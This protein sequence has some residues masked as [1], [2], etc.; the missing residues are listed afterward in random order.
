MALK[1]SVEYTGVKVIVKTQSGVLDISSD[2]QEA[3]VSHKTGAVSSLSVRL[4]NYAGHLEGKYTGLIHCG[5]LAYCAFLV[6][7]VEYPQF[8]GRI[9]QVPVSMLN[10]ASWSF[11]AMDVIWDLQ[12]KYWN[13]YTVASQNEFF[14]DDAAIV[15]GAEKQGINDSGI[16]NTLYTFLLE[17]AGLPAEGVHIGAFPDTSG[18]MKQVVK[19]TVCNVSADPDVFEQLFE[20]LF[21]AAGTGLTASSTGQKTASASMTPTDEFVS[22]VAKLCGGLPFDTPYEN[23]CQQC[24]LSVKR[25]HAFEQPVEPW[26]AL[27]T[28]DTPCGSYGLSNGAN[29]SAAKQ[30][31]MLSERAKDLLAESNN[32]PCLAVLNY[33]LPD[34]HN[35][36]QGKTKD[37]IDASECDW[38]LVYN[39]TVINKRQQLTALLPSETTNTS[40][41]TST[42]SATKTG[43]E[44]AQNT[45]DGLPAKLAGWLQKYPLGK[46]EYCE[47]EAPGCEQ[48]WSY[49][50]GYCNYLWGWDTP[51]IQPDSGLPAAPSPDKGCW[52]YWTNSMNIPKV[53]AACEKLPASATAQ[54]GDIVF[55][56]Y[57]DGSMAGQEYAGYGHVA[58]VLQDN[59]NSLT[60]ANQYAG[61]GGVI[62]SVDEKNGDDC[63]VAGYL[64]PIMFGNVT[65]SAAT[66]SSSNGGDSAE[67]YA[68]NLAYKLFRFVDY[69]ANNNQI[70]AAAMLTGSLAL[71]NCEPCKKYV[72]ALCQGSFRTY[73][74]LPDGSFAAFVPDYFGVFDQNMTPVELDDSQL[75]SYQTIMD[76]SSYC[77][78]LYVVTDELWGNVVGSENAAAVTDAMK[79]LESSGVIT[80]EKQ[81]PQLARLM[82]VSA[83]GVP[84]TAEGLKE[85]MNRWGVSV[86]KEQQPEIVSHTLTTL[87]AL[88]RFLKY[89]ANVF[90]T[91]V[92]TVF[93]PDIL[94][95]CRIHV[96]S[97]NVTCYVQAVSHSWSSEQG[98]SSSLTL[99]T[100]VSDGKAGVGFA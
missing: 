67:E 29:Y 99:T 53:K 51:G 65:G 72:D 6:N 81:G 57:C 85:L 15:A 97:A 10:Q 41:S 49:F 68:Y 84:N 90:Q 27:G 7:G 47:F 37:G 98:G 50:M 100:P 42:A 78:H 8:T 61:S 79:L 16:G 54:P 83:A 21:G 17:V 94:P 39:G 55:F 60:I 33:F 73:M 69:N 64:R 44:T 66:S 30:K 19:D 24:P 70:Q 4:V 5:D 63:K 40:T 96:T 75:V 43:S 26:V 91:T 11:Q 2:V 36:F 1:T 23:F 18:L 86:Q 22:L 88:N 71:Y 25:V 59:G 9:T 32:D 92:R 35:N 12:H 56:E 46:G 93:R 38:L 58:V 13:P 52:G 95:G 82:D 31:A 3:S 80:L 14:K 76:E 28:V 87:Y 74:S 77:S 34:N 89:W 48:C 20:Q 45:V 62:Q